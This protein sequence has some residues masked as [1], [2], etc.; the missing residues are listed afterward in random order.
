[1]NRKPLILLLL[2]CLPV[3]IYAQEEGDNPS[4]ED[5]WEIYEMD[6]YTAGDQ[7]FI[8]SVGTTFPAVFVNEG[9]VIPHNFSPPI[10]GTG[11]L[12]YNYYLSS[13]FFVGAEFSFVFN[14]TLGNNMVYLIPLG[15]RAGYQFNIWRLEFPLNITLGMALHRYLNMSYLGLFMKG[16]AA[17]Y[18]RF[19]AD[20]SFGLTTNWSWFPEW[21]GDRKRNVDGNLVEVMLSAR[22]H[23]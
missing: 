17:A 23:F 11:A 8:I 6:L 18:Y 5:D 15:A 22:Y 20:W 10:G 13:N 7:T 14:S 3:L 21:T 2:V 9:R 12:A 1:M 16:G 19:N 4:V